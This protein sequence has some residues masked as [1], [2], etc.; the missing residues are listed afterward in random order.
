VISTRYTIYRDQI[1]LDPPEDFVVGIL[2]LVAGSCGTFSEMNTKKSRAN[3][4]N[5]TH[6]PRKITEEGLSYWDKCSGLGPGVL[7]KVMWHSHMIY[8]WSVVLL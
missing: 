8:T 6:Y 3:Y 1:A 7:L 5:E 2:W 4:N